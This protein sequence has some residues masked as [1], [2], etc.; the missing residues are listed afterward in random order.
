MWEWEGG[1][2]GREE[3]AMEIRKGGE[4][5]TGQR[6]KGRLRKEIKTNK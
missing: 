3:K 4:C 2:N 5:R 1:G 6:M